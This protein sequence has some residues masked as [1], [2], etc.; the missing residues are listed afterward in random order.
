MIEKFEER[1]EER[2]GKRDVKQVRRDGWRQR[3]RTN[4]RKGRKVECEREYVIE[5]KLGE[6][7]S[8]NKREKLRE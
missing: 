1:L 3:G 8:E 5:G 7:A 6:K 2:R 4:G